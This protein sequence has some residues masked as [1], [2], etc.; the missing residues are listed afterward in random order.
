MKCEKRRATDDYKIFNLNNWKDCPKEGRLHAWQVQAGTIRKSVL[1]ILSLRCLLVIQ[2]EVSNK[3]S[4]HESGVRE[5]VQTG[6][7]RL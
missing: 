2:I 5:E 3:S 7:I 1:D 4:R 6:G